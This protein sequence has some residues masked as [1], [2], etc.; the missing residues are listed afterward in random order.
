METLTDYEGQLIRSQPTDLQKAT[1]LMQTL[2]RKGEYACRLFYEALE[3]LDPS[4]FERVTGVRARRPLV[5]TPCPLQ[6]RTLPN[7]QSNAP[8]CVVHIQN[9]T[10]VNCIIG[11]KNDQYINSDQQGQLLQS[12]MEARQDVATGGECES[13]QMGAAQTAASSENLQVHGSNL[14][15][16]IIGDK[17]SLTVEEGEESSEPEE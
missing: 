15:Y 13:C 7:E 16:V 17:N 3:S 2:I 9:S 14:E 10:L 1:C 11:S 4:L 12:L 5:A 6:D 8:T